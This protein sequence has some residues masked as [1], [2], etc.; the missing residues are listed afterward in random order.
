MLSYENYK[1]TVEIKG[2]KGI[3]LY[4]DEKRGYKIVRFDGKKRSRVEWLSRDDYRIN[5]WRFNNIEPYE[6]PLLSWHNVSMLFACPSMEDES[7]LLRAVQND[8]KPVSANILVSK[9]ED[10]IISWTANALNYDNDDVV[11]VVWQTEQT[12]LSN[13][14]IEYKKEIDFCRRGCLNDYFDL[15]VIMQHY[16]LLGLKENMYDKSRLHQ[17]W[18]T[19]LASLYAPEA[20]ANYQFDYGCVWR[21]ED[22]IING[23]ALGYTLESTAGFLEL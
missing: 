21:V 19:E 3:L 10:E 4:E 23:L 7:Y 13:G 6:H 17:L 18:N 1:K 9:T 20:K 5:I 14:N 15:S 2:K 16:K 11:P 22:C 12:P 8:M